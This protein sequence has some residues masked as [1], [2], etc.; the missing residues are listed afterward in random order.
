MLAACSGAA[1]EADTTQPA[2]VAPA[3]LAMLGV[4]GNVSSYDPATSTVTP[5]TTDAGSSRVYSQPT[6]SPDGTRL[7]FVENT[8]PVSGIQAAGV[9]RRV[10]LSAQHGGAG[11]VHIA[12]VAGGDTVVVTTPFSPFYLYWS[13]DGRQLAFL[14]NDPVH[15]RQAFGIIDTAANVAER[16]DVG[17]PYYF[18]W[19]PR[20]DRLLVHAANSELYYLDLDGSKQPLPQTPGSFSAPGWVGDTQL[21]PVLEGERQILRLFDGDGRSRRDATDFGSGV[22]LGLSPD[23]ERVAYIEIATGAN[24]FALGPLLVESPAGTAE[25]AD[26]AAAFFWSAD[27]SRLLYLTPDVGSDDFGLRWNSWDG[28]TSIEF[29]RFT[30]TRTFIQ[31]YLPFFGQYANSL[32]F[33]SP[34]ANWF[35]FAGSIEGKGEGIWVQP[36]EANAPAVL[37]GPGEFSTWSP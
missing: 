19:S 30:P 13:P 9:F 20:S 12:P 10:G 22:A 15:G 21:F 3:V 16:V 36:I 6:W 5:I 18:A 25:I 31:Q 32:T 29:E 17:Q 11:S 26:Q 1:S 27:G 28:S 7:A 33:L 37:I 35:T 24:P 4:D 8:A 14:G 23:E 2:E 34:D